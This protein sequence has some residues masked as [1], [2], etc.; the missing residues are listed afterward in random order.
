MKHLNLMADEN[1][2]TKKMLLGIN[3]ND[4]MPQPNIDTSDLD[5]NALKKMSL[6]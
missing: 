5:V 1:M 3:A 2:V 4:Q 6:E